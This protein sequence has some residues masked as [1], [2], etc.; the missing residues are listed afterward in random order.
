VRDQDFR[1][2]AFQTLD[3]LMEWVALPFGL[4]NEQATFHRMINDI[5]RDFVHKFVIVYLDDVCIY[6]RTLE[7]HMEQL[8]L[9]PQR[10]KEEGLKSRLKKCYFG[11]QKMEYLGYTVLAGKISVST[12]KV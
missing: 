12:K 7:E 11:L 6:S 9:V 3:G 5:L 1:K 2:T 4:C 10:L 8:R